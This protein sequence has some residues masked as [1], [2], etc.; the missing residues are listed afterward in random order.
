[1]EP[2]PTHDRAHA[3]VRV[4]VETLVAL[5]RMP[6]EEEADE[7]TVEAFEVAVGALESPAT[8]EEAAALLDV[9]PATEATMFGAAWA[10]LHFIE[11]SPGWPLQGQLD[12]RTWWVTFLR[13]RAD[14]EHLVPFAS[15]RDAEDPAISGVDVQ[16]S[17]EQDRA[18]RARTPPQSHRNTLRFSAAP[19]CTRWTETKT[20][21]QI[22][23]LW[24][25]PWTRRNGLLI[26]RFWV[27]IP[28]GAP[29]RSPG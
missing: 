1:M 16:P 6:T 27:R 28:G 3:L 11:T 22:R 10:V 17:R 5:G 8:D 29:D 18:T 26:R 19:E 13:Q 12:D 15:V 24:H 2:H 20:N 9:L 23:E 4:A 25:T 7:A 21:E 14:S